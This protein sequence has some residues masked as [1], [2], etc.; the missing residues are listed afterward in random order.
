MKGLTER[1][2]ERTGSSELFH[3]CLNAYALTAGAAGVSLLALAEPSAG[4][5]IYT[6]THHV[7]A[8][9]GS[10]SL[11]LNHDGVNDL[12]IENKYFHYCTHTD[13][14][15]KTSET[16]AAKLAGTNKAVY[17]VYGAVAMKPRMRIGHGNAFR[18]GVE[19]MVYCTVQL[20]YPIGSW[21]NVNNRYLG[22]KFKIKGK[23]HYG[24]ARLSVQVQLPLTI[25]ATLTGYAYETIP[26]RPIIAGKTKGPDVI[27]VQ[28]GSLGHL[29]AGAWAT[30][31]WR[32]GK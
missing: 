16:L 25:T 27:T 12:T 3:R 20:S 4:E 2:G 15:C 1:G 7:I 13:T 21:I 24:W 5:I 11:D 26:N 23:T 22:I 8:N 10:Y 31:A 6:R 14:F 30:P 19:R 9:G 28:P 29:A 32:S 17:D 18:G